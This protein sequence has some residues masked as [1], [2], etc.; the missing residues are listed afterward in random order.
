MLRTSNA[1]DVECMPFVV[2]S[3]V[4]ADTG[5]VFHLFKLPFS[6]CVCG[7]NDGSGDFWWRWSERL[8]GWLDGRMERKG[9]KE[10]GLGT[11]DFAVSASCVFG[12]F[13]QA[14]DEDERRAV[15]AWKCGCR[16]RY[17]CVCD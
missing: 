1:V 8:C 14:R 15:T 9:E 7:G 11:V 4:M 6:F 17:V 3:F 2:I 12:L 10:R 16:C 5:P 13:T